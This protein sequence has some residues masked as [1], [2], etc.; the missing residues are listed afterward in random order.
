MC[1]WVSAVMAWSGDRGWHIVPFTYMCIGI[2]LKLKAHVGMGPVHENKDATKVH[3]L[4]GGDGT[5]CEHGNGTSVWVW[6]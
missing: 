6:E 2:S 4:C 3:V 1:F 5:S